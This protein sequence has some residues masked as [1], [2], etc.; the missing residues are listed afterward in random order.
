ME[1]LIVSASLPYAAFFEA[2]FAFKTLSRHQL[3]TQI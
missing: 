3:H 1:I 2:L